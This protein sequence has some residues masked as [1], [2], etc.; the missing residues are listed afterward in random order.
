MS[1]L[2]FD[3]TFNS[4]YSNNNNLQDVFVLADLNGDFDVDGNDMQT[5]SDNFGMTGATY[6]DGDL[7]G[8]GIIDD[9]DLD[10]AFAQFGL[11]LDLVA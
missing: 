7:N 1:H 8:D 10:L 3:F 6:A 2:K 4:N 11:R 5:I 9:A